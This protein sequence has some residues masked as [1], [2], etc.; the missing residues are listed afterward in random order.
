MKLSELKNHLGNVDSLNFVQHNGAPI[1]KHFHITEA[2]LTT[3]HFI[4][5]GGTIREEK[6]ANFQ[7]WTSKDTE[8]RLAPEKLSKILSMSDKFFNNEDLDIEVEYQTDT[9]GKYGL[10]FQSGDFLLTSKQTDCLAKDNC[11]IPKEKQELQ[12]AE[13]E[14]NKSCCTPGG[15]CC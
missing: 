10:T 15:G 3:K 14:T 1:P 11:G 12:L 5:C 6:T 2:G 9:V 8:H 13:L 7:I 4:D